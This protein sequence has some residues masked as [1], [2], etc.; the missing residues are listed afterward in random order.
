MG[1]PASPV[2]GC[3]YVHSTDDH[4]R[5]A[6]SEVLTRDRQDTLIQ[7]LEHPRLRGEHGNSWGERVSGGGGDF[8][9]DL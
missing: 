5:L 2:I 8:V 9:G 6:C 1:L 7:R 3:S 4:S